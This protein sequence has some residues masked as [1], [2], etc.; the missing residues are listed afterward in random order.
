VGVTPEAGTLDEA[1]GGRQAKETLVPTLAELQKAQRRLSTVPDGPIEVVALGSPHFSIPEFERLLPLVEAEPPSD[2]VE[3]VVCTHRVALQFL[4]SQGLAERLRGAGV[5]IIVDTCVVVA[6]MLK[7]RQG[8]LMTNS[9]KFAHY[10]PGNL[11][12]G[13]VYGSLE[14]CV[15]S[16]ARGRVVRLG[17]PS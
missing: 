13:V 3:F 15:R 14:E 2:G 6:P 16:A 1:L 5:R 8:T 11:G 10:T 4:E 7:S 9:G 12:M 17:V